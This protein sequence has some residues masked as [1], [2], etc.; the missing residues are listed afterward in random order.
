MAGLKADEG[1]NKRRKCTPER[2]IIG[3]TLVVVGR[4]SI[5]ITHR[6]IDIQLRI[7][8]NVFK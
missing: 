3:L 1:R 6:L 5:L 2:T 8:I 4:V 7:E